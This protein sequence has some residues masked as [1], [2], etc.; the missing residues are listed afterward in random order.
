MTVLLKDRN[1][2]SFIVAY[3]V[4]SSDSIAID[5]N[6]DFQSL[7]LV[8]CIDSFIVLALTLVMHLELLTAEVI[9]A[10]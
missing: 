2:L 10:L 1:R 5:F 4:D 7:E 6:F 8:V 3:I 9:V